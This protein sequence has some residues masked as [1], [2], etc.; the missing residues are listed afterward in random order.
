MQE[1][2]P[3]RVVP[4]QVDVTTLPDGN[5]VI[6]CSPNPV[7]IDKGA[8]NVLLN[9]TLATPGYRF[10]MT[11]AI[12]LDVPF[13]DFPFASWTTSDVTAALYDRNKHADDLKYTVNVVSVKTEQEYSVDPIIQNGGGGSGMPDC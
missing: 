2:T 12:E 5:V 11:K 7:L 10:K 9:F 3:R 6:T 4:V 1:K 8:S 13:D